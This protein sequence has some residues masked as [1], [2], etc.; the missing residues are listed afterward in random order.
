[1]WRDHPYGDGGEGK[2]SSYLTW[3][4]VL[5]V[6]WSRDNMKQVLHRERAKSWPSIPKTLDEYDSAEGKACLKRSGNY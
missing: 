6:Q 1:M 3:E 5:S 4:N 2:A